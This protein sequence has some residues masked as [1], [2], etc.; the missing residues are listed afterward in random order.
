MKTTTFDTL[1]AMR[2]VIAAPVAE[3]RAVYRERLLE[4]LR[5][6]WTTILSRF[7]P[8]GDNDETMA[9]NILWGADLEG[10][11]SNCARALDRLEQFDAWSKADAALRLA[12]Q[13]FEASGRSCSENA[14]TGLLL[15]G[16]PADPIFMEMGRGYAGGQVD[17]YVMVT[18]WPNEYN[19]PRIPSAVVHEFNHR[20][21]LSYEPWTL[22]TSV[23]QYII[24]EGLAE[25][26]A[27]ELYGVEYVGPWVT[28]LN[29][30][31]VEHS[32]A[33]IGGALAVTGF[34]RLRGYIF[35]DA[36]AE[37]YGLPRVGL[38][39]CAGY[40]IGYQVVQAYLQRT[41]KS[42][43]EATFVPYAEIIED[44]AFFS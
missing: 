12:A 19:L 43:V 9:M 14:M 13:T 15:L 20:V 37:Q 11:L 17:G 18:I 41:G 39:Y 1:S 16:N 33:I 35:G 44:S 31:E 8:R 29:A 2:A 22:A 10:D 27:Q 7:A 24:L 3:R 21:R 38:P 40:T 4:P 23:G 25:S 6:S 34:D 32:K 30:E 42:V 26:F 5:D 36:L 28:G